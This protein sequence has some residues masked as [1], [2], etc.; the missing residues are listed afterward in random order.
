MDFWSVPR[1][2]VDDIRPRIEIIQ[3][4]AGKQVL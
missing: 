3:E 2:G 4:R 1:R